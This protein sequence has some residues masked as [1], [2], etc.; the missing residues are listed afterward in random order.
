MYNLPK[1]FN[2]WAKCD[3][4]KYDLYPKDGAGIEFLT[5]FEVVKLSDI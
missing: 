3:H 4:L 2:F 1:T 5:H